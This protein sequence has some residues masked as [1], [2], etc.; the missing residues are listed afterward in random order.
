MNFI[1]FN[2][3]FR[4][5]KSCI[6]YIKTLFSNEIRCPFCHKVHKISQENNRLKVFHCNNCNKSFSIFRDTIFRKSSTDLR[7]WLYAINAILCSKKGISAL[8]LQR[9]IS[10]TYKTAWRM[11]RLIR[12]SMGVSLKDRF[13]AL[14]EIDETY[15]GGKLRELT[16]F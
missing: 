4:D 11:L 15:V 7:K 16:K 14:V 3:K 9:E 1:D 2:N 5:I 6:D 12:E 10:V 8:Q 13:E